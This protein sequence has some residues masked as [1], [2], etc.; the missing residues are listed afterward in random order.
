[1]SDLFEQ[2]GAVPE[3][4][5]RLAEAFVF[6][7]PDPVTARTLAP[8]LPEGQNAHVV[9]ETLQARCARRGVVLADVNGAWTF[10]TAPDLADRFR[11]TMA[12]RRGLPRV[13]V[14]VLALIALHQ[15]ITRPEIEAI[16]GVSLG[17][18][19]MDVLL[20]AGLIRPVGRREAPGR[21]TLWATTPRLLAQFGLRSLHDLP[22]AGLP[23]PSGPAG[24]AR[25]L[26]RPLAA[27]SAGST[28]PMRPDWSWIQEN[29]RAS[30]HTR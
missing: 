19:S 12:L 17:Q 4:V 16:R 1:M 7:S 28:A 13:P 14:E 21:P 15:P 9:L 25:G 23:L 10:R 8:L 3:D 22:G 6:A 27:L 24:Q 26:R 11:L 18:A 20:E 29:K 5:L 30:T 2:A